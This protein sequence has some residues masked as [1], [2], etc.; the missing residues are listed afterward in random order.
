MQD[1]PTA[2]LRLAAETYNGPTGSAPRHL[3]FRRAAMS[4]MRWEA[5][6]GVLNPIDGD[7]PGSP[8]WRAMNQRLLRDGCE[9]VARAGGLPG[10]MS[11]PTIGLWM[12]FVVRPTAR[13]WYRAHNASIVAAY[14]EHLDLAQQE[15]RAERFFLNV[16][17]LRVLYAHAL[18]AAP[19]L[20]LGR[21]AALG[22]F[23]GDPR[24]GMA[25]AFLSLGRVLPSRYPLSADLERY[26]RDEHG[27]GRLLDY[28]VIGPRLPHLY[29]WSA[30]ELGHPGLS[31]LIC[32]GRPAYAWPRGDGDVWAEPAL[33]PIAVALRRATSGAVAR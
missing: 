5:Q 20:A 24:L 25:G 32:D 15:S 26:L 9:A 2:R 11:S 14:L 29:D 30:G 4:F 8:W 31:E 23:L 27:L 10:E 22:R 1:S 17:L 13:S 28:A 7:P 12:E 18:V 16:V 19:H 3:P 21:L 33:P 6:R